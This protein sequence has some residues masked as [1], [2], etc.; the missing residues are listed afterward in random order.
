MHIGFSER[1][2]GNS[3]HGYC[4]NSNHNLIGIGSDDKLIVNDDNNNIISNSATEQ[5]QKQNSN[6]PNTDQFSPEP[7]LTSCHNV[8][9]K[10]FED[11]QEEHLKFRLSNIKQKKLRPT[12]GNFN[13]INSTN[14]VT[15]VI[16]GADSG[17][18]NS[19]GED[20]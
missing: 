12:S 6:S 16:D 20:V 15:L 10:R 9:L 4:D 19:T 3:N 7:N 2:N 8:L 5:N 14:K 1:R 13:E 18:N 17:S 11:V